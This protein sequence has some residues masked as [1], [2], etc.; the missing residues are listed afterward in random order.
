[1]NNMK[2]II[3]VL[4]ATI[5]LLTSC[6]SAS[7]SSE[8]ETEK[9]MT[10]VEIINDTPEIFESNMEGDY[11]LLDVRTQEEYDAGHIESSLLIPVSEL[12]S[13]LDEIEA[14]KDKSVLVYCRS[15]N[16]SVTASNILIDNGFTD[17]HNLLTGYNGWVAYVGK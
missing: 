2:K 10:K 7:V 6:T 8:K 3:Y 14:Y 1:M 5:A 11:L 16:R 17:V 4:I 9:P 15:G 12:E 13:R